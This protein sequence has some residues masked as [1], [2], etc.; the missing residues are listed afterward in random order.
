M[1][2]RCSALASRNTS[3]ITFALCPEDLVKKSEKSLL[4]L[5]SFFAKTARKPLI[6]RIIQVLNLILLKSSAHLQDGQS[7]HSYCSI[8]QNTRMYT[9][10][11]SAAG[12]AAGAA[13]ADFH[14]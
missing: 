12:P 7:H 6:N 10:A 5:S 14:F 8:L 4:F 9:S 13:H 11:M 2:L 3:R 1:T